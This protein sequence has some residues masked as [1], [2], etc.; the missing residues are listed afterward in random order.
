MGGGRSWGGQSKNA[1]ICADCLIAIT[2]LVIHKKG[3]PNMFYGE[4]R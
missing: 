3:K 4:N 2:G 1:S